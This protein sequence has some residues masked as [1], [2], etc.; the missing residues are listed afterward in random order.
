MQLD[1]DLEHSAS[2]HV[3]MLHLA[4]NKLL[5][6]LHRSDYF[7]NDTNKAQ[8]GRMALQAASRISRIIEDLLP[9]GNLR[10]A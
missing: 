8:D 10:Y 3:C 9:E 4:Y 7:D 6:V 1:H 2:L 5:V